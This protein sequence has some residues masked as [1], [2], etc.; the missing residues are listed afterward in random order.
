M[1]TIDTNNGSDWTA[2]TA[3]WWDPEMVIDD[4]DIQLLMYI[5]YIEFD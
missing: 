2:P 4:E 1:D 5:V 3:T